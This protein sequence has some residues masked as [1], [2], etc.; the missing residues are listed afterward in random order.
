[1]ENL[2]HEKSIVGLLN[3]IA[4]LEE[5]KKRA[6]SLEKE[7]LELKARVNT[8][9]NTVCQHLSPWERILISRHQ[10]RP[11][12]LEIIKNIST[13][14]EELHGDRLF[15]D[16]KAMVVGIADID[17]IST[18]IITQEKGRTTE[19]RIKR[20]FGM[21]NPEGYRKALRMMEFAERFN[22]P[23]L[24]IIDTPGAFAG[25]EAEARGQGWAISENLLKMAQ[26]KTPFISIITGEGCSGGALGVCM[27]DSI[28]IL[29]HA[30]YSVISPDGCAAILWKDSNKK[31]EAAEA[32]K[33]ASEQLLEWDIVDHV[34][35]EP[36]G[37]AHVEKN[38]IAEDIQRF[39][40]EQVAYLKQLP[41]NELLEKRFLKY[42]HMGRFFK[43]EESR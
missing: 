21:P 23:I 39:F 4:D 30:Y 37:G 6:P 10:N 9:K 11:R 18:A 34:I 17:G 7:I 12:P 27:A 36:V 8:L 29:E 20:N 32:L 40:I 25:L 22:L 35:K 19:E 33:I 13:H 24:S 41:L 26:L 31:K 43:K 42:R 5:Q 2:P 38:S 28:A 16:D 1:M 15:S 14:F 3:A